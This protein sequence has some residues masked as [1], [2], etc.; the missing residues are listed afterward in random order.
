MADPK[1]EAYMMAV[2]G[3]FSDGKDEVTSA[4][5]LIAE[6]IPS[7]RDAQAVQLLALRR[8]L[9]L[10]G[11]KVHANWAWT[12]EQAEQYLKQGTGKLVADEAAKVQENFAASNPGFSLAISPLRSL[13]SQVSLWNRNNVVQQAA[14]TLLAAAVSELKKPQYPEQTGGA[15]V[16]KFSLFLNKAAV[17]PEPTSAAPGTS[18]HGQMR[19]V[20]FVVLQGRTVIA[21]TDSSSIQLV[22]KDQGWEKKLIQA[23]RGTKLKGPLRS[24]YEPWHWTIEH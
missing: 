2:A 14:T 3:S 9:R 17:T 21:S 20:D 24:P 16:A 8:Y 4:L 18:D 13:K 19:A 5:A 23:T 6:N 1:I 15:S 11:K 7:G 22:W 12:A 10:G